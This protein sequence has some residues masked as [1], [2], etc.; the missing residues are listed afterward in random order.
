[1][2]VKTHPDGFLD[3]G[4]P[5]PQLWERQ[6]KF[7]SPALFP[8]RSRPRCPLPLQM[9]FPQQSLW[10]FLS[11]CFVLEET[12]SD[13]CSF[14]TFV[15]KATQLMYRIQF[16]TRTPASESPMVMGKGGWPRLQS[17]WR[18]GVTCTCHLQDLVCTQDDIL[19]VLQSPATSCLSDFT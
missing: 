8:P 3:A 7:C 4:P 17:W 6:V 11:C 18:V 5:S 16:G 1:M 12:G 19:E 10:A 13:L 14:R 9:D 15:T 2:R